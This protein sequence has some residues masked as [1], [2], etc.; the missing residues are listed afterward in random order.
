MSPIEEG[1][2]IPLPADFL[3]HVFLRPP[4][5]PEPRWEDFVDPL[6]YEEHPID[7]ETS[8]YVYPDHIE[9]ASKDEDGSIY[10]SPNA[11]RRL[12]EV[13]QDLASKG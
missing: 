5:V 1:P 6:G 12:L 8:V 11:Q 2:Q 13:L 7:P 9:I 3:Q 4:G 10:L